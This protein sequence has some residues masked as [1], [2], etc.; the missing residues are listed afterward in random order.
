[1]QDVIRPYQFL[2]W[3][4]LKQVKNKYIIDISCDEKMGFDFALPTTISNPVLEIGDNSY[5]AVGN[6]PAIGWEVISTPISEA[7]TPIVTAFSNNKFSQELIDILE[8]ATEIRR[9]EILNKII[10]EYQKKLGCYIQ[11]S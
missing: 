10:I 4:D 8:P 7:L 5:Y 1:M 2:S 3:E 9:G 6:I 11:S